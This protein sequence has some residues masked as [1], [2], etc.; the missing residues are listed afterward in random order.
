MAVISPFRAVRPHRSVVHLVASRAYAG[1]SRKDLVQKLNSND[2]SFLHIINPDYNSPLKAKPNS[3][4]RFQKVRAKYLEFQ[5]NGTFLREE[6]P[7]FYVYRQSGPQGTFTGLIAGASTKDYDDA[8]IKKHEATLIKREKLFKDYLDITGFNAEPVLLTCPDDEKF[9]RII[10][11]KVRQR[12]EYEFRTTDNLLHELWVIQDGH[13]ITE[14][15]SVFSHYRAIYIADGHHRSASSALLAHEKHGA[16]YQ[17]FLAY[18]IPERELQILPYHRLI[19]MNLEDTNHIILQLSAHFNISASPTPVDPEKKGV[20][21][22]CLKRQWY[23][24]T[25]KEIPKG[26]PVQCLD[27]Y[28]ATTLILDPVFGIKDLRDD[29]RIEFLGGTH[30]A[31][32]IDAIIEKGKAQ[33]AIVLHAVSIDELKAVANAGE[34]MPPKST[35]IEP[36]LRSGLTIYDFTP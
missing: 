22:L 26:S 23:R 4:Q 12:A 24:C 5:Q 35:W 36:K 27:A 1:Y 31:L 33:A 28:L 17:F 16:P 9:D 2:Y 18:F 21:G 3:T 29:K 25:L 6:H 14:L 7:A 15:E 19:K 30:H 34:V 11:E 13:A 20:F 8:V 10:L 32:D